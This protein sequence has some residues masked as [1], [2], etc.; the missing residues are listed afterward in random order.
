M[1]LYI[2][3]CT[4]I[5]LKEIHLCRSYIYIY[6]KCIVWVLIYI[7]VCSYTEL[8]INNPN[9]IYQLKNLA[10]AQKPQMWMIDKMIIYHIYILAQYRS[11]TPHTIKKKK[12]NN[13]QSHSG[14]D[15]HEKKKIN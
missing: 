12:L 14:R 7:V 10:C 4:Y 8:V 15:V 2:K 5:L 13:Q 6:H 11:Q 9:S 3:V 1:Y